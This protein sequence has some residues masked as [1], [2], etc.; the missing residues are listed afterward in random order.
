MIHNVLV[1]LKNK[2]KLN[3]SD[4]TFLK[5]PPQSTHRNS[6][7]KSTISKFANGSY[8]LYNYECHFYHNIP[9]NDLII[10]S[11]ST[12]LSLMHFCYI[13]TVLVNAITL[14]DF[15]LALAKKEGARGIRPP[16]VIV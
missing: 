15:S 16:Y 14:L 6:T 7:S 8:H 1:N 13:V 4:I 10:Y 11:A 5:V 3:E 9:S 2:S 12:C